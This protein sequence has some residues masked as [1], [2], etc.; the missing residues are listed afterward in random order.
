MTKIHPTAIVEKDVQLGDDVVIGPQCVVE[1]PVSIGAGTVIDAKVVISGKVTIGCGNRFFPSSVIGCC[2]Q[3][4]GFDQDTNIGELVIGNR[5]VVR[6]YVTI[7]PSRYQNA[8]TQIGNDNLLMIGTHIGH[9]CLV[10][11][12]IVL[13]NY[14]QIGGHCRLETGVWISGMAASHQFV[15]LGAWCF[16]AGL[17]GLA[18]DIPPFLIVSGQHPPRIRGVNKRGLKRAGLNVDQQ[19]H[20]YTAYKRLYR[21]GGTLLANAQ[22]LA[23]QD[24]LDENVRAMIDAIFKSY[25][26]R[27]GRYRE[28]LRQT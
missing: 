13:S 2:P 1:G 26:H 15:T 4:L 28:T 11:D 14:V 27:F 3:V 17:S 23:Q 6:E 24:G 5:N 20:I 16:V 21:Q 9:D 19:E 12:R 25:R 10:E 22:A 18:R 8:K 7:H